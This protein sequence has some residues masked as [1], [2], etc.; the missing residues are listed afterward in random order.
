[1]FTRSNHATNNNKPAKLSI[2][3]H[4]SFKFDM[5]KIEITTTSERAIVSEGACA[6]ISCFI[7]GK[8]WK[9]SCTTFATTR[10]TTRIEKRQI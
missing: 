9:T 2:S 8:F 1:M 10:G 7:G 5:P 6:S 3:E 4:F